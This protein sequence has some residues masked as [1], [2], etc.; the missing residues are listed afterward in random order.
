LV[1][2]FNMLLQKMTLENFRCYEKLEIDFKER[3]TVLVAI[4]G[5][6]KTT[7]LDSIRIALW[8]YVS[9]FDLART[10]FADPA[11]TI[12]I[13][14]VR[15]IKKIDSEQLEMA[16]Q[17][18]STVTVTCNFEDGKFCWTRIRDSEA[19]RSQTKDDS[20]T[21]KLKNYATQIQKRIRDFEQQPIA[22]PIFGYYGTGRLWKEKR[23]TES[24]KDARNNIDVKIRTLAYK[25]CL[26]PASSFKQFEDWFIAEYKQDFEKKII[27]LEKGLTISHTVNDTIYAVREAVN[28]ILETVGWKNLTYNQQ[29][30]SLVLEHEHYGVMKMSQLSDGIKNMIGM[31]ADI[32]YR[33]VLLNGHL[34]KDAARISKG[35]VMIDEI[36]MHLHPQWQQVVIS[37]LEKAFQNIQFIVTTHSPQVL[38]TVNSASICILEDGHKY[39]APRG[40]QGAESSRLLKR[41]FDVDSRPKHIEITKKLETYAK[42]VYDDKWNLQQVLELRKEL[43][44]AFG[45]EEPLLTE[46][47]LYI[48]NR[49]WELD[50]EKNQ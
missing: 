45:D 12:T 19:R 29:Y 30:E 26:D 42:Y 43:D 14:D 36:D 41:I 10:G 44:E 15:T 22:L 2:G 28:S 6:G 18:P 35:L 20:Y 32:A 40:S 5:Q 13:D 21:K 7:I 1:V 3:T 8:P 31:I 39:D 16:R 49:E 47:D 37:S 4:N 46:L 33:C 9:Q 38:T 34:G 23:L 27:A 11:N 24:K 17:L 48:E 50:F 25:D